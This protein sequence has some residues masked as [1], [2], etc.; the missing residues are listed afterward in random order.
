MRFVIVLLVVT[1]T[2]SYTLGPQL[3]GSYNPLTVLIDVA[4]ITS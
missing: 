3:G 4:F 2:L 1:I